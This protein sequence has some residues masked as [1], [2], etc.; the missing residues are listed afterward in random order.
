MDFSIWPPTA[1]LKGLKHFHTLQ[2]LVGWSAKS[3]APLR[4][5]LSFR[6][7]ASMQNLLSDAQVRWLMFTGVPHCSCMPTSLSVAHTNPVE[8]LHAVRGTAS[9]QRLLACALVALPGVSQQRLGHSRG[10]MPRAPVLHVLSIQ[11][12]LKGWQREPHEAPRAHL[13]WSSNTSN[14]GVCHCVTQ[15]LVHLHSGLLQ[16]WCTTWPREQPSHL[17][18]GTQFRQRSKVHKG[19]AGT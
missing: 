4:I 13:H 15:Q 6:G 10:C 11:Q 9:M 17:K 2:V 8:A 3:H 12:V 7:T 1:V 19:Q 14:S 18:L 5:V 16:I